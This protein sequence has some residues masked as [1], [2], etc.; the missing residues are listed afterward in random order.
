MGGASMGLFFM[1]SGFVLTLGYGQEVYVNTDGMLCEACCCSICDR[2][3][4]CIPSPSLPSYYFY[5]SL[6]SSSATTTATT[7]ESSTKSFPTRDFLYKRCVRLGPLYYFTNLISIPIWF[8][9]NP[10]LV[11]FIITTISSMFLLTS[12]I[13]IY[14]L[15]GVL[16]SISTMVFFYLCFPCLLV[17]LQRMTKV[18]DYYYLTRKMYCIQILIFII[19]LIF[20][21]ILKL[22]TL[23]DILKLP[24]LSD[25]YQAWRFFPP[26]RLPLFVMGMCLGLILINRQNNNNNGN[27]NN[28][29][30]NNNNNAHNYSNNSIV[31]ATTSARIDN[32]N[33]SFDDINV[34]DNAIRVNRIISLEENISI[35]HI[36]LIRPF[37]FANNDPTTPAIIFITTIF[38]GI[39]VSQLNSTITTIIR[40]FSELTYPILYFDWILIMTNPHRNVSTLSSSVSSPSLSDG[41]D[42]STDNNNDDKYSFFEKCLRSRFFQFMGR[43]SM[44][45][46]MIHFIVIDYTG[47]IVHYIRTGKIIWDSNLKNGIGKIP[48]ST[49]PLVLIISVLLG[50]LLTD[51]FELPIQ[52]WS[53]KK[54]NSSRARTTEMI[55]I[56][57]SQ[58]S[59]SPSYEKVDTVEDE[60]S[61]SP[62]YN[63][64]PVVIDTQS[65]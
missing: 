56:L 48:S 29:S 6:S 20:I 12:W 49:I 8:L 64:L 51:N 25:F 40:I 55:L 65:H 30:N 5:P 33:N 28:N 7:T 57:S 19:F 38:I 10:N 14:P 63:A 21:E 2:F 54:K 15:N 45:F 43:I 61:F 39:I 52:A 53:L 13:G 17:R 47:L 37:I 32:F 34:D 50:W 27:D 1:I 41:I 23:S 16:W 44:C 9:I 3:Y 11:N 18:I 62:V 59:S 58:S 4:C 22:P 26:S 60:N 24:T 36:A 31:T 46:Y 42:N 35:P